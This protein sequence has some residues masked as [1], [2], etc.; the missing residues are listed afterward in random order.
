[1]KN[2]LLSILLDADSISFVWFIIIAINVLWG[3]MLG[4]AIF[5]IKK[6]LHHSRAH[7]KILTHIAI[8]LDVEVEY[9]NPII[10]EIDDV[11]PMYFEDVEET[12]S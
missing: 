12:E 8:K 11:N 10:E 3:L 7:T 4:Q 1:M 2:Y 9:L 6:I 5:N